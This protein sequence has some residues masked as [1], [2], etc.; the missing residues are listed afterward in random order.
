MTTTDTQVSTDLAS[1][2]R[3]VSVHDLAVA[4]LTHVSEALI[5][6]FDWLDRAR[7]RR[8]LLGLSDRALQ[9]FAASR[10][11]AEGEASKPFW[12]S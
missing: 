7:Q 11:D 5:S 2:D 12:R 9:D 1:G 4:A 10:A 6:L 8:Q 3:H